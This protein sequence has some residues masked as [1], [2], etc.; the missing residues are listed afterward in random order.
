MASIRVTSAIAGLK[1]YVPGK[2]ISETMRETGLSDIIKLAS[3]ENPLGP[4]PQALIAIRR[5]LTELHRYPDASGFELKRALARKFKL[6]PDGTQIVL[7]NGSDDLIECLVR[8][9][10]APA[11]EVGRGDAIVCPQYSFI[12]YSVCAQAHGVRVV[13]T[14]VDPVSFVP[15]VDAMIAAVRSDP[16]VRLVF[17]ANPNNPTGARVSGVEVRRLIHEIAALKERRVLIVLDDAY[18]EYVRARDHIPALK[19][20]RE[21]PEQIVV[22]KTFS[23]VYGLGGLRVGYAVA[24]SDVVAVLNK[25]RQPFNLSSLGLAGAQAALGDRKFVSR[26]LAVN[27]EGMRYLI[28]E[29]KRLKIPVLPSEGN[30]LLMEC[31]TRFG[32]S[33]P[34]LAQK[35]LL[36]GIILRPIAN[37]GETRYV[38]VSV[39]T[40]K[41]NRKLVRVLARRVEKQKN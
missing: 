17:L 16:S 6:A 3:N 5:A 23:K 31:P 21:F 13:S 34:E 29:L 38:R 40:M 26:S 11:A 24:N 33:G 15:D 36:E 19:L 1:P 30:F 35:I 8:A 22:L 41:E 2:P 9:F 37:Y 28:K 18:G 14:A 12:A 39:G 10:C 20:W 7:G 4:S 25:V 27:R 32:M